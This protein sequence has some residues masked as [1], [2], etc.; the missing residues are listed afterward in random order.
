MKSVQPCETD[1]FWVTASGISTEVLSPE[2]FGQVRS[3]TTPLGGTAQENAA[4]FRELLEGQ[5]ESY[6]G[7]GLSEC[8]FRFDHA[9]SSESG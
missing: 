8:G 5:A 6:S 3:T 9:E 7:F 4:T 1:V 2:D